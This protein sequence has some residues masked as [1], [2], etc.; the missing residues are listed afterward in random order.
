MI[1]TERKRAY[2]K[3]Y[4]KRYRETHKEQVLAAYRRHYFR[5]KDERHIKHAAYYQAHKKERNAYSKRRL[6]DSTHRLIF[7]MRSRLYGAVKR[8][9]K[10]AGTMALIG[11]TLKELKYHL[12][13][14]F[15]PGMSWANYGRG[16]WDVDHI[17]PCASFN[18]IEPVQQKQCFHYSN[19]QPLWHPDNCSK[20]SRIKET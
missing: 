9:K 12:Q 10:C 13:K 6:A 3:E 14:Q 18:L 8:G 11:C 7:N 20:G 16:G 1:I 17:I 15:Q 19:L 4:S 5:Y 2:M